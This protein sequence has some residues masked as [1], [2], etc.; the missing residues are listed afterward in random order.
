MG[1]DDAGPHD[2]TLQISDTAACDTLNITFDP[3]VGTPPFKV[4]VAFTNYFPYQF[5]SEFM[6]HEKS[7]GGSRL[8]MI[9]VCVVSPG[10]ICADG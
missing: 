2:F 6:T 8:L 1:P 7:E 4:I 9:S 3:S 10:G 5:E